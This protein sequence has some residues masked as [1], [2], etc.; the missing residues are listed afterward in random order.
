M[1]LIDKVASC[2]FSSLLVCRINEIV[3]FE[4]GCSKA[5][6]CGDDGNVL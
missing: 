1:F 3:S 4:L 2:K 5:H 6:C